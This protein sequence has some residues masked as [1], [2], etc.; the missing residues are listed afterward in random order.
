MMLVPWFLM[1]S[2]VLGVIVGFL[3]RMASGEKEFPFAPALCLSLAG[4]IF[5]QLYLFSMP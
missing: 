2:G 1:A 3:W 5:Y 4:C